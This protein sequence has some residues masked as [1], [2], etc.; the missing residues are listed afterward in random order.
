M[1]DLSKILRITGFES[2]SRGIM[3]RYIGVDGAWDVHLNNCRKYISGFLKERKIRDLAVYGS[4]WLLD[5]PLEEASSLAEHVWLFDLV[6]PVQ[7]LHK[8][9]KFRNVTAVKADITG[10]TLAAVFE[11]M[12]LYHRTGF[13]PD[14]P[15]LC[16]RTFN[17]GTN[18]DA[19]VSL[20]ILSQIGDL[21][22]DYI[23][24]S[25]DLTEGEK[26][27]IHYTLQQNHLK[28]LSK[29]PSCLVTDTREMTLD[30]AGRLTGTRELIKCPLPAGTNFREW[31]WQFDPLKE[32]NPG[33]ITVSKVVAL[34]VVTNE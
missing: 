17:P 16:T 33:F 25:I 13:K 10:G 2:D 8:L 32:Y 22:C 21:L 19:A 30:A 26:D 20:N 18:C 14:I 1:P 7:I 6:H 9:K 11:A 3:N 28:L 12:Q 23:S 4:G 31:E 34:E 15:A 24:Q 5:F 29:Q 27:T